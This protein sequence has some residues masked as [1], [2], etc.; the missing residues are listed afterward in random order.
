MAINTTN[1]W[2][3]V[4][5]NLEKYGVND[6]FDSHVCSEA[7]KEYDGGGNA[8][9]INKPSKVSVALSLLLLDAP[10]DTTI[11]VGDT[12][13]DLGACIDV[14]RNGL[15]HRKENLIT[16]GV[17]WGFEG[18]ESLREGVSTPG[19]QEYFKHL[20]VSPSDIISIVK[21]YLPSDWK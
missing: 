16:I 18:K 15:T 12:K 10:G 8:K 7:L 2:K 14:R 20:V 4:H 9:A 5:P 13:A 17:D 6:Y 21:D 1:S 11:F 3:S 19:G